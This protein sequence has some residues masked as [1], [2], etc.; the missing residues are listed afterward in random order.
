MRVCCDAP[1]RGCPS[2]GAGG[3]SLHE[4]EIVGMERDNVVQDDRARADMD[5]ESVGRERRRVGPGLGAE[6]RQIDPIALRGREIENVVRPRSG[7]ED[8]VIGPGSPIKVSWPPPPT[9]TSLPAPPSIRSSPPTTPIA[10]MAP[11]PYSTSSPS[12][13]YNASP[14]PTELPVIVIASP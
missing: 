7:R 5:R 2:L 9:S 6:S 11:S 12:L 10:M 3:P 14:A 1:F 4:D 13:P 8:E